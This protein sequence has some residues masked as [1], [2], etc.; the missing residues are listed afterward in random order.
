MG[1]SQLFLNQPQQDKHKKEASNIFKEGTRE[2][3]RE[4][5]IRYNYNLKYYKEGICKN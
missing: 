5:F 1:S 4:K 2:H 3:K